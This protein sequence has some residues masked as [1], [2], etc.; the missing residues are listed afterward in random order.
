MRRGS[1]LTN[2]RPEFRP[3]LRKVNKGAT[4]VR[5]NSGALTPLFIFGTAVCRGTNP[6]CLSLPGTSLR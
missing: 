6:A 2:Q 1:I 5:A 4:S 3:G